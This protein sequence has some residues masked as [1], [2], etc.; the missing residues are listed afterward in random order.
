MIAI[1]GSEQ[2]RESAGVLKVVSFVLRVE[3]FSVIS[4]EK[5]GPIHL[6]DASG[7]VREPQVFSEDGKDER[8]KMLRTLG[9]T[10]NSR[11]IFTKL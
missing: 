8:R 6:I 5:V 10:Y 3:D 2:S 1:Y 9:F 11:Y 7:G 4:V